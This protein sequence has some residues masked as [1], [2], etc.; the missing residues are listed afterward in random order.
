MK[1]CSKRR[2]AGSSVQASDTELTAKLFYLTAYSNFGGILF[3]A[4]TDQFC[5][6]FKQSCQKDAE[7]SPGTVTF[8]PERGSLV[9]VF[10]SS[11]QLQRK[12]KTIHQCLLFARI[13]SFPFF[14]C[15]PR[16]GFNTFF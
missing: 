4:L 6:F 1:S 10:S 15:K 7:Q 13:V 12:S 16:P 11:T 3:E 2:E 9:P 14:L 8:N 5:L